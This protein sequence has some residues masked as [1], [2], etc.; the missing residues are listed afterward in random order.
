MAVKDLIDR[1]EEEVQDVINTD[2]EYSGATCVP[3]YDDP[4]LTYESGETKKGKRLETCVLYADIRDS[5]KLNEDNDSETMGQLYTAFTKAVLRAA[6]YHDGSVRNIIGDRVMVVFPPT[7]CFKNAVDCAVSIN[8]ISSNIINPSFTGFTFKCGIGIDYGP[9]KVLKVGVEKR[10]KENKDNKNLVWVGGPANIASRL[11]DVANKTI[12]EEYYEVIRHPINP[13]SQLFGYSI[14][15]ALFPEQFA[16]DPNAPRY[17]SY[18]ETVEKSKEEFSDSISHLSDGSLY[19]KDGKNVS[20]EKKKRDYTYEP[21]LVTE[22]VFEGLKKEDS[23]R[24]SLV[25]DYW[26]KQ[27]RKVNNVSEDIFGADLIWII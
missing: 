20:F 6:E 16:Y 24:N 4:G 26:D 21:I 19:M 1:V 27:T 11:T 15:R 22:S 17:L 8:H 9:M 10:G 7:L 12:E 18:T 14:A 3:N 5:V 25:K 2:F 23:K 13:R